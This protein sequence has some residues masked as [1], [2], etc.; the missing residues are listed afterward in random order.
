VKVYV[1]IAIMRDGKPAAVAVQGDTTPTPGLVVTPAYI[2]DNESRE[3]A[4]RNRSL[5][6]GLFHS[7]WS[8]VLHQPSGALIGTFFE[9]KH[10]VHCAALLGFLALD[11]TEP[12]ETI[13]GIVLSTS[14]RERISAVVR[15]CH[16]RE[17]GASQEAYS[18]P[19]DRE[20]TVSGT[21]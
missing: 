12:R 13:K 9:K 4:R 20:D 10:A 19:V 14:L 8:Q 18:W 2:A 21:L 11:W 1:D 7:E 6:R 17:P 5:N 3:Q 16:G 15:D